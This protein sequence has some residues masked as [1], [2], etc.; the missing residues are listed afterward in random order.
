MNALEIDMDSLKEG[1]AIA[2]VSTLA[3]QAFVMN[4]VML[5]LNLI[6]PVH[7]F[8]GARVLVA[9]LVF[10]GSSLYTAGLVTSVL[11][12]VMGLLA[13]WTGL[14]LFFMSYNVIAFCFG[15]LACF[16]IF[17]GVRLLRMT[18]SE[19]VQDHLLFQR[20]CYKSDY[21]RRRRRKEVSFEE[22]KSVSVVV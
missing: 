5:K 16:T 20:P 2:F 22:E 17:S 9:L 1:G 7:P 6:I 10:C 8:P 11:G 21:E 18:L 13:F 12:I 19:N 4:V 3:M 15:A 14:F